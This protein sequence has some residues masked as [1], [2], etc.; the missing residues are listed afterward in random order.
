MRIVKILSKIILYCI[1]FFAVLSIILHEKSHHCPYVFSKEKRLWNDLVEATQKNDFF[2][3]DNAIFNYRL[4]GEFEM[5]KQAKELQCF[6]FNYDNFIKELNEANKSRGE[7]ADIKVLEIKLKKLE[8]QS[9]RCIK[10]NNLG[11]EIRK[12]FGLYNLYTQKENDY[13]RAKGE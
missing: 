10:D 2:R 4:C 11:H 6:N 1:L 13:L 12:Q 8:L 5:Y 7:N 9:H 3:L